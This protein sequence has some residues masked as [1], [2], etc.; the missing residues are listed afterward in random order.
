ME[1]LILLLLALYSINCNT[2]DDCTEETNI[3]NCSSHDV[4]EIGNFNCHPVHFVSDTETEDSCTVYPN[5]ANDQKVYWKLMSGIGKESLS[6]LRPLFGQS[7]DNLDDYIVVPDKEYYEANEIINAK[8]TAL[9]SDDMKII[10][11]NN[12]CFYKFANQQYLLSLEGNIVNITDRNQCFNTD[13]FSDLENLI[14]CGYATITYKSEAGSPFTIKTCYFIPD[15]KMPDSFQKFFKTLFMD[16]QLY[17]LMSFEP[18]EGDSGET[19]NNLRKFK[20][21]FKKGVDSPNFKYELTVEDKYGKKY[22]Y[23]DKSDSPEVIEEGMQGDKIYN[24]NVNH[25][26]TTFINYILLL[27]MISLILI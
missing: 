24:N 22:K 17:Q 2:Y 23:T 21:N 27:F 10:N 6:G 25:S 13:Q 15:N 26:K 11:N 4:K 1:R 8:L 3:T 7:D 16:Y 5:S 14:N 19:L 12:T 20:T 18:Q 9:S